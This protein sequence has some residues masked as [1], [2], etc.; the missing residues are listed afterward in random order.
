MPGRG[1]ETGSSQRTVVSEL[2]ERLV[3]NTQRINELEENTRHQALLICHLSQQIFG[4]GQQ[5][6]ADFSVQEDRLRQQYELKLMEVEDML[7]L[8]TAKCAEVI[9]ARV[10]P[11]EDKIDRLKRNEE[12]LKQEASD[13]EAKVRELTAQAK[14]KEDK[15]ALYKKEFSRKQDE[16]AEL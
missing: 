5:K 16:K 15:V 10:A 13:L 4:V 2:N 12:K 3:K 9:K 1:G 7:S 11:L 14:L 6:L 8:E